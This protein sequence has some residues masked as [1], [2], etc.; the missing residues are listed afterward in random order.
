MKPATFTV[1]T[2]LFSP[3]VLK[4]ED[5]ISAEVIVYGGT[6]AGIMASVAAARQ[7]H[8]VALV[9]LNAHVGGMVS[10]GLV[11]TD[12]GD[13]KT[14][15]GLAD[16]FFRRIV[17]FYAEKYGADSQELKA[18]RN[19]ATFEPHVAEFIFEQM[20]KEQPRIT[21]WKRHRYR[22][23]TI[24]SDRSQP[25]HRV[26]SLV[27]DDLA[28]G[29]TRT[30]TGDLFI[31]AS[32]EG[33]MMAGARVPYRIGREGR[34]EYGELL[35]G[36]SMGPKA[37]RGMGDHRTQA[38][39][40]RVSVTSNTANRVLFPKPQHYDPSPF[41][42]TDGKRVK[43]GRTTGFGGFFTTVDKAHP[44][45]KFDANW[46]DF[47]GNSEGYADGD[48]PTRERIAARIR[49]HFQSRLYYLQNGP[50]LPAT[51]RNEARTWGLPKDEFT[52]NGHWPFQLYVREGRRMIGR[53][54]LRE[55]DLTQDRW[56]PDGIATGSYGTDCHIVQ[57]LREDGRLVPEHT[58]HVACNNYDI[59]YRSLVPPD[60]ENLLV[61]VCVSATHVAYC[62]LR[63][64]PVY[65]M[66]GH[67]A[68][69]AA[70]LALAGRSPVQNVDTDQLRE[71]LLNEG[72][73]LDAGYQPQVKLTWT[74]SHPQ[75][76]EKVI[77]KAVTSP[78]NKDPL[79]K[80]PLT[81]ILWDFTGSGKVSAK[82]ERVVQTFDL[83]KT[84]TVSLLVTD[85][86]GRRRLVTAEVPVGT[87]AARDVTMDDFDADLFGRWNGTI[88]EYVAGT[89]LRYSDVFHGPGMHRD[90]VVRGKV[91][92][93][94]VRF[95]PLLSPA[96]RYLVCLGF[97]PARVQATNTPITIRHAG[98]TTKLGVDQR[99]ETT[100]FNFVPLGEFTFKAGD[101]GF[102]EIRNSNTD[103]RVVID[104][105]RWV[106]LGEQSTESFEPQ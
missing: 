74:P 22:A 56:K 70:H 90:M 86:V 8:A 83:D 89:P 49:D 95:Q 55:Q 24:D 77:F 61:P 6:P 19:G 65:M 23:V 17:K 26:T 11:A 47:P 59:P 57:L 48:W 50:D 88:P 81:Q 80:D 33:D 7:G 102:V 36:V 71:L 82:G 43:E 9:D 79:N 51:F 68:G 29:S 92:P 41:V 25:G 64:E 14:V 76:G 106:W 42:A 28:A 93:A 2:L 69:D 10:G 105:V 5:S 16:D 53:Y 46:G 104:G 52:D 99:R 73:V 13:R 40:Y 66:L 98:G 35:A 54:V 1:I 72:A 15:G 38:Y 62:S 3:A 27:V 85:T 63:M 30:F 75:P 100:P 103:G 4:A 20:L 34:A 60:V 31:D 78:L 12:M 21:V 96:G 32:Y 97:R 94:R 39:N 44:N 101:S 18:C 45:A 37:Q 58:R 87:A 91:V 67:A 84:Y